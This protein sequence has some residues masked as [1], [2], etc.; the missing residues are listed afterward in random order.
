M[1]QSHEHIKCQI[2]SFIQHNITKHLYC[3]EYTSI[4]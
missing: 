4:S 3:A 1:K 2:I